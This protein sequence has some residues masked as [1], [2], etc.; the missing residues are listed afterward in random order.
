MAGR[1]FGTIRHSEGHINC[2]VREMPRDSGA[3]VER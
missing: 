1:I 3:V 2:V